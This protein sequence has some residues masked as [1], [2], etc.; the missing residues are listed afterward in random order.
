MMSK[1]KLFL[2]IFLTSLG[3]LAA[4]V[5]ALAVNSNPLGDACDTN[6]QTLDSPL[7]KQASS[8][9]TNNPISGTN[10]IISKAANIIAIVAALG[11]TLNI[12]IG[13]FEFVSAG[14]VGF[15]QT[16]ANP[17]PTKAAKARSRVSSGFIGLI[18]VALAWTIIRFV[19]DRVIR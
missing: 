12:I 10:G 11:A 2:A 5:N 17:A 18:I 7:C 6:K 4:P 16:T 15:K 19:I 1:L 8:Q 14:G 13:A 3:L 9:G